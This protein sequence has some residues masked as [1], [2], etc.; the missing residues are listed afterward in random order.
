MLDIQIEQKVR[1]NSRIQQKIDSAKQLTRQAIETT[2]VRGRHRV[3]NLSMYRD[4]ERSNE[5][6]ESAIHSHQQNDD[7]TAVPAD[8]SSYIPRPSRTVF[9]R[10]LDTQAEE[11]SDE[12]KPFRS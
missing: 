12:P 6:I 4:S 11:I 8:T 5:R 1:L 7:I 9:I 3:Q 2:G 10:S